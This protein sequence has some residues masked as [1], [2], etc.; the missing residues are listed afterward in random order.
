MKKLEGIRTTQVALKVLEMFTKLSESDV[1][2]VGDPYAG[3]NNKKNFTHV[4]ARLEKFLYSINQ[5]SS[6][7][8]F[9]S[10]FL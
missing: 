3:S 9:A 1:C 5:D 7:H 6:D 2:Y 8:V 4:K 10:H